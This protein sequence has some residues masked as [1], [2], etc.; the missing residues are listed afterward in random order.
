MFLLS[1]TKPIEA[2]LFLEKLPRDAARV[3]EES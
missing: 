1:S 3:L 2:W